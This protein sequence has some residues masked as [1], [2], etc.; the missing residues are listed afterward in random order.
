MVL[1]CISLINNDVGHFLMCLSFFVKCLFK[2]FASLKIGLF[3]FFIVNWN[4]WYILDINILSEI[5]DYILSQSRLCYHIN[6]VFC[7]CPS[8]FLSILCLFFRNMFCLLQLLWMSAFLKL[9]GFFSVYVYFCNLSQNK[10]LLIF[11][12]TSIW[13]YWW[14]SAFCPFFTLLI[15]AV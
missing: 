13:F 3:A 14:F 15:S 7:G 2:S 11:E 1:I 5:C 12:T 9:F 10:F 4:S 8:S 6:Y